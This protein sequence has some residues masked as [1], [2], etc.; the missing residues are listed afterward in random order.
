VALG[1]GARIPDLVAGVVAIE[2]PLILRSTDVEAT[3]YSDTYDWVRWVDDVLARR[4]TPSEAVTRFTAMNP[5]TGETEAQQALSMIASLDPGTIG[6]FLSGRFLEGFDIGLTLEAVSCP[7][8]LLAGE[9]D[10]GGLVR[11]E[12]LEYFVTHTAQ[13]RATRIP[14]GGHGMVWDDPA[15]SV[16][17]QIALFLKSLER[18]DGSGAEARNNNG[19]RSTTKI[20]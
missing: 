15:R 5:C 1:V 14:G 10:L 12:D 2:P 17:S 3:S 6:P 18:V 13:G 7:A 20:V 11:D 16:I 8:L 4:L 9:V 19:P